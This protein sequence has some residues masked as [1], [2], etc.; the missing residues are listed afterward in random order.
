MVRL[1]K[2]P[3]PLGVTIESEK[4][5]RKGEVLSTLT[6]DCYEKCYICE[7]KPIKINIEHITPHR[8]DPMLKFDWNNL[9]LACGH[10]NSIKHTK[11]DD[12]IDPT[13][14]DPEMHIALS[15][16]ITDNFIE[17]VKIE[18]LSTDSQATQTVELL[19]LI[20]NEGSTDIQKIECSNLRNSHLVPNI[21]LFYQFI[22]DHKKEPE[23]GYY[24]TICKEIDRSSIYAAFKRKIIRDDPELSV[25]FADVLQ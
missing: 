19:E 21:R 22:Q 14:C 8:S 16:E 5:Y 18:L 13:K 3:L 9:F 1:S 11:Y 20:Y 25:A 10:C 4:D 23:L 2:S 12:I 7:D 15:V 24:E 6:T 17:Q